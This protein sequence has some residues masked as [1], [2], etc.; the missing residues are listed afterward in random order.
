MNRSIRPSYAHEGSVGRRKNFLK[1]IAFE[2][3]ILII[4][5][6]A[7]SLSSVTS[8]LVELL[9]K[10]VIRSGA[11][12]STIVISEKYQFKGKSCQDQIQF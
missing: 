10:A 1:M 9:L 6:I 5:L 12:A 11:T 8:K 7:K 3:L 4:H 2:N